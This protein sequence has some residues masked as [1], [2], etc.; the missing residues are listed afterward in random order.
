MFRM[1]RQ[2][3]VFCLR[4]LAVMYAHT[5]YIMTAKVLLSAI[6][7]FSLPSGKKISILNWKNE[8]IFLFLKAVIIC[9]VAELLCIE[10]N[11]SANSVNR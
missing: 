2:V 10:L 9:I 11:K 4:S 8:N 5:L 7:R 6:R 3:S 1:W